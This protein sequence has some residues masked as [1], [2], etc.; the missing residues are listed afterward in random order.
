MYKDYIVL[1]RGKIKQIYLNK[2]LFEYSLSLNYKIELKFKCFLHI[3][4]PKKI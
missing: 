4:K 2:N 1:I 3:S